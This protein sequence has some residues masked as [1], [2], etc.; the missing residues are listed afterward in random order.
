MIAAAVERRVCEA[1][2]RA[3]DA[4]PGLARRPVVRGAWQLAASAARG[5]VLKP[6]GSELRV[7]VSPPD[8]TAYSLC[9]AQMACTV[10]MVFR[11][12]SEAAAAATVLAIADA[13][14]LLLARWQTVG[15]AMRLDLAAGGF[16]PTSVKLTGGRAPE[17][18]G[19]EWTASLTF[20]TTG[21]IT[22]P[23]HEHKEPQP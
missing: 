14:E 23:D 13:V 18:D 4:V 2:Q 22:T 19:D 21:V 8:Y 10:E 5:P 1:V 16:E 3:V 6:T 11:N 17:L 9:K 20:Y 15:D 7:S 12:A